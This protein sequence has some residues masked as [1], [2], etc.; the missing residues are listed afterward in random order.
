MKKPNEWG[1]KT[2]GGTI[3]KRRLVLFQKAEVSRTI[4]VEIYEPEVWSID[5]EGDK[6]GPKDIALTKAC[7]LFFK[8]ITPKKATHRSRVESMYKLIGTYKELNGGSGDTFVREA[9]IP[10][11]EKVEACIGV[12]VDVIWEEVIKGNRK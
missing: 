6:P 11:L 3:D 4:E 10:W 12:G 2:C 1:W 8:E 7:K 9:F 5:G